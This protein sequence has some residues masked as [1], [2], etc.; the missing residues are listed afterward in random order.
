MNLTAI[1]RHLTQLVGLYNAC[2]PATAAVM[3]NAYI[4]WRRLSVHQMAAKIGNDGGFSTFAAVLRG[5]RAGG[6]YGHYE[7]NANIYWYE[8]TLAAGYPITALVAYS[9]FT[10]RPFNYQLAHFMNI[11]A[12][13]DLYVT[14][15]DPLR[16]IGPVLFPRREFERAISIRS[17][18]PGG[19]NNPFQ[20]IVPDKPLT[21]NDLY[22]S[23]MRDNIERMA[24]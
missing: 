15:F 8:E 6:L 19:T 22:L 4:R 18:Y 3:V 9:A 20:A 7:G 23:Q 13:N 10:D 16:L 24:A 5:W 11:T 2:G 12:M 21:L 17:A 1:L 14:A